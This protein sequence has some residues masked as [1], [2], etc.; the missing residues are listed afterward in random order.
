MAKIRLLL[1]DVDGVLTTG[2]LPY[3]DAGNELKAFHV[4]DG[5]AIKLWKRCGG[6]VGIVSG[7]D[8][9]AVTKRAKDLGIDAVY[10]GVADKLPAYEAM[11]SQCAVEEDSVCV[12]GDDWMDLGPMR[13]CGYPVAVAN[14]L[15]I[16]KRAA[17][18]V[19]RRSGGRGALAEV[20]ERLLRLNG[21]WIDV[22]G[23]HL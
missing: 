14:A 19:T 20:V 18:F 10:L 22:V 9:P 4:Q 2:E 11:L 21:K 5:T 1:L 8:T 15:P 13:R 6:L 12:V 3:L 16:V 7:R 17:R 23:E